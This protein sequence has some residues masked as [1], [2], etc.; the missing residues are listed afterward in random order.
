MRL[1]DK[2]TARQLLDIARELQS[3]DEAGTSANVIQTIEEIKR[4][5]LSVVSM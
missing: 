3:K 5:I 1:S 2:L 4:R